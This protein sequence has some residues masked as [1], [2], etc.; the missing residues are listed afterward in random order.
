MIRQKYILCGR[1]QH[2]GFRF[3]AGMIASHFPITGWIEN[4]DHGD[5]ELQVQGEQETIQHFFRKLQQLPGV[6]ITHVYIE[7][8]PLI[9]E[10]NFRARS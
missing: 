6:Q 2:I 7:E 1:V 10:T 9:A 5:V 3:R 4:L 8:L